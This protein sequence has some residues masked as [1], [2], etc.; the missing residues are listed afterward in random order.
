MA[1]KLIDANNRDIS[2]IRV[3][4]TDRC[5]LRCLYCMPEKGVNLVDCND[6][7]RYEEILLVIRVL[8]T[9]G[10]KKVKVTGGEPLVRKGITSFISALN[11]IDGLEDIGLLTNGIYLKDF[12]EALRCAGLNRVNISID[13]LKPSRF[14]EITRKNLL[15]KVLEGIEEAER[16]GFSPIKLN[17]V[18]QAGVNDDEIEDFAELSFNKPFHVR[19]IEYMPVV[20]WGG[21]WRERFIP[22]DDIRERIERCFGELIPLD[23]FSISGPS[24]DFKIKGAKGVIGF[25]AAVSKS[26]CDSCNRIRLT[27]D[28]KIK[29]CLFSQKYVDLREPLRNACS[30]EYIDKLFNQIMITKPERHNISLESMERYID[31]SMAAIGG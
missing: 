23:N 8:A 24:V 26:F 10:L 29:Q 4:V 25:I 30:D 28:G 5:N 13:T 16:V 19:F 21:N 1:K 31:S 18:V 20:Q 3:S 17:M 11:N 2:Y 22:M 15:P 9:R 14:A 7:L 27:S 12:A 6:V